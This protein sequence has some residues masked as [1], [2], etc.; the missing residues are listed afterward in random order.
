MLLTVKNRGQMLIEIVVAVGI[1]ALVLIG[2]SDLMARSQR[3]SGY[4]TKRDE[5]R[6]IAQSLLNDF[7]IQN[8]SDPEVFEAAVVG[9]SRDVCVTGK[10]YSCTAE[11]TKNGGSVDILIT[12]SWTD[13]NNTL[14]VKMEQKITKP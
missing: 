11:I 6:S 4:Q 12:V 7:R 8:Q 5:A 10:E 2:V 14:S 13:G 9:F 3:L 1:L